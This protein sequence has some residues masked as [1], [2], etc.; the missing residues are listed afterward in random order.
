MNRYKKQQGLPVT[1]ALL[2]LM[3]LTFILQKA[4]PQMFV[5]Y[6]A[7]QTN[8]ENFYPWQFATYVFLENISGFTFFFKALIVFMFSS[9][10]ETEWTSGKLSIFLALTV[11][12]KS[13]IA[14]IFAR[15]IPSLPL[16]AILNGS[17]SLFSPNSLFLSLMIAYGFLHREEV[18][19]L[20]FIIPIKIWILAAISIGFAA[21]G[22]LGTLAKMTMPINIILT[23]IQLSGYLGILIFSKQIFFLAST[24]RRIFRAHIREK[25]ARRPVDKALAAKRFVALKKRLEARESETAQEAQKALE[26]ILQTF[27]KETKIVKDDGPLCDPIDFDESDSYCKDCEKF[28]RCLERKQTAK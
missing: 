4:N 16:E 20:F 25:I 2:F 11:L 22:I 9:S 26:E 1:L 19:Y 10:L 5:K 12:P 7:L 27:E 24:N 6:F 23:A 14:A 15:Y 3:I 8:F 18:I 13:I 17:D 21:I 28:K